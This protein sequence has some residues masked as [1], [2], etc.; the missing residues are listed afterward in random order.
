MKCAALVAA[1]G[2]G[3]RLGA[4]EPKGLRRLGDLPLVGHAVRRMAAVE[5]V[6]EVVVAAPQTHLDEVVAAVDA[7]GVSSKATITVIAGGVLRQDSVRL[8]LGAVGGDVTH[9]LV[10]DAARSLAPAGVGDLVV[11][12][13]NQGNP[14]VIPVLPV[15]DTVARVAG[16]EVVGHVPRAELALVQTPQ[17]FQRSLLERAHRESPPDFEAT[18]DASLVMRLGEKV[19]TVAGDPRAMKITTPSD[20]VVAQAWLEDE[21]CSCP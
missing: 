18:D 12:A 15:V 19:V 20:F 3:L 4:G 21:R 13:M 17:G 16:D 1:G 9:V 14:A 2:L 11:H 6:D 8:M 5:A 10:H 7:A